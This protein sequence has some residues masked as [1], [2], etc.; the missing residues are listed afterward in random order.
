MKHSS[1]NYISGLRRRPDNMTRKKGIFS[2][3]YVSGILALCF[4]MVACEKELDFKYHDIP[5]LTVIEAQMTPEK[6]TCVVSQTVAMD[7]PLSEAPLLTD[8]TVTMIDLTAGESFTLFPDSEGVFTSTSGGLTGHDYRLIVEHGGLRHSAET[9]MYPAVEILA[10][11][12]SWIRMPYDDVAVLQCRYRSDFYSPDDEE[13]YWVKVYRNGEIYLWSE[14]SSR[15]AAEGI[16]T[17]FA[18][19]SR[20]DLDAEDEETALHDGDLVTVSI[21]RISRRMHD[22][23]EA[24]SNDSNGPTMFVT[25]SLSADSNDPERPCLGYF[26]A[27]TPTSASLIFHPDSI[28]YASPN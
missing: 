9:R 12:F 5:P 28:P 10:T 11:E 13:Y 15:T 6:A 1:F 23:L 18:M 21:S 4:G 14:Q 8:A 24:L 16:M 20:R 26:I 25:S 19:T 17:F 3:V 27:D 22:Y 2:G 7:S